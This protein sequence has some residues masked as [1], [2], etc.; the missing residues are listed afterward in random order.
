MKCRAVALSLR[1]EYR[2]KIDSVVL[3]LIGIGL[4]AG[5]AS[6]LFGIG[7]GVLVV[8]A[9]IY[10]LGFSQH[11]A[12]GTSLVILLPPVG[13]GA[14]L[15]YYRNGNVDWKAAL[16][17]AASVFVGAWLGAL[18][19]NKLAGPI[20]R[21]LFGVFV[22]ALG[23]YTVHGALQRLAQVRRDGTSKSHPPAPHL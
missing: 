8:P 2:V 21:L 20:L 22:V 10:L 14:V 15:E 18:C 4:T 23:F 9:L 12:T 19:S 13:L 5:F 1:V 7:G 16:I 3:I 17:V 6:G 11:R